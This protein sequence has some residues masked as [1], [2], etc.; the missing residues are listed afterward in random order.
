M[1]EYNNRIAGPPEKSFKNM[2]CRSSS[3]A[4]QKVIPYIPDPY[5]R[6]EEMKKLD[7]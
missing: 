5:E 1:K 6:K 4:F 2:Q 7:Y 3:E